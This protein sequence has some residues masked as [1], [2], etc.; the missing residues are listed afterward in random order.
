MS[1]VWFTLKGKP[2]D[3]MRELRLLVAL[4]QLAHAVRKEA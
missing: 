1:K 3:I 2:R 4:E